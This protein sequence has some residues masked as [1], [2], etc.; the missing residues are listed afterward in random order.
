MKGNNQK[1]EQKN[2]NY[3]YPWYL[4]LPLDKQKL[5]YKLLF[6]VNVH[7]FL[8]MQPQ[9][10]ANKQTHKNLVAECTKVAA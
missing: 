1:N 2:S 7:S 8:L 3:M 5:G 6:M 4:V 9:K 10:Q